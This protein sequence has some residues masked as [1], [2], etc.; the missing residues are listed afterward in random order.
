MLEFLEDYT[1][2]MVD[3]A[4]PASEINR[5]L[6][7]IRFWVTGRGG[8]VVKARQRPAWLVALQTVLPAPT[9]ARNAP[10][11]TEARPWPAWTPKH[12][13]NL[14]CWRT[15]GFALFLLEFVDGGPLDNKWRQLNQPAKRLN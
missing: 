4:P 11:S 14:R 7:A 9:R 6:Q 8:G 1:P 5:P 15:E 3:H 13:S 12:R 2:S 10:A